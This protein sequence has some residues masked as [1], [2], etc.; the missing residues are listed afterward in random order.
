VRRMILTKMIYQM[1]DNESFEEYC[2]R[3]SQ[4]HRDEGYTWPEIR[5]IINEFGG[6]TLTAD[7]YRK[8]ELSYVEPEE[9]CDY[10]DALLELK[11]E[12]AKLADERAQNNAIIR[13]MAREDSLKEMAHAVAS[14]MNKSLRLPAAKKRATGKKE[15]I[16][17]ISDWHYGIEIENMWNVFNPDV[18]RSRVGQLR[19]EVIRRCKEN[20]VKVL[21]VVNL[22]DLIAGRIHLPLRINSRFDV[23]TQVMEVTELL[24][25]ML[26]DLNE[27][28]DIKYYDTLD[29]HS[30]LEPNLK[31]SLDLESLARITTWY[32]KE[33]LPWLQIGENTFGDDII[34]FETLGHKVVGVHGHKDKPTKIIQNMTMMTQQHYDLALTAHL[35]HF[36][37]DEQNQTVVISNASLMGTDDFAEKLR[38]TAD[39]AQNLIIVSEKQV[40]DALYRITLD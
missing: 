19:D 35:H 28:V 33:R 10:D 36:S 25:Q 5:D 9:T 22:G 7:G 8:K 26:S 37:A 2:H 32:L 13:R 29:N 38:L 18:A 30:R 6:G 21:H 34:T 4:L 12:R 11:M 23:I 20:D 24:A 16:L 40:V 1:M 31:E 17:E 3:I 39:P 27:I 14:E 15:A